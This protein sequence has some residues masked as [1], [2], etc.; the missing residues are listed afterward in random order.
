M[1]GRL[2]SSVGLLASFVAACNEES[3]F[4]LIVYFGTMEAS[5]ST[6]NYPGVPSTSEWKESCERGR[7]L[8][9]WTENQ[10]W[11]RTVKRRNASNIRKIKPNTVCFRATGY[12]QAVTRQQ[13]ARAKPVWQLT[14][15]TKQG[16]ARHS[17]SLIVRHGT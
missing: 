8:I 5:V 6:K 4:T 16:C 15:T 17:G 9:A 3:P 14:A 12:I 1:W 2:S 11:L 10:K 7:R 13:D